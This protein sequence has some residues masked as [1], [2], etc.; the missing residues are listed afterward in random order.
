MNSQ[1]NKEGDLLKYINYSLGEILDKKNKGIN[2]PEMI[3]LYEEVEKYKN[4]I[5][6]RVN[7][8][9]RTIELIKPDNVMS[10][11]QQNAPLDIK[12]Y[13]CCAMLGKEYDVLMRSEKKW[14][15]VADLGL[16]IE[17]QGSRKTA[18]TD[19]ILQWKKQSE[20][21][22]MLKTKV[23]E[24]HAHYN[25]QS[26]NGVRERL[27]QVMHD[28]GIEQIVVPAIEYETNRQVCEMF[29]RAE[30]NYIKYAF[31]SH[32]K[33]LWKEAWSD[34]KWIEYREFLEHPKCVAVGET[35]LDYSYTEFCD[36]HRDKQIDM[37]AKFISEANQH[38]LPVI[39]HIRQADEGVVCK[40]NADE[41]VL[42][43][44]EKNRIQS[45]AILHCFGGTIEDVQKY[46]AAGVTAFGI[47]G[48][49]TYGNKELEDAVAMMPEST[50]V[51]ETDAPYIRVDGLHIP[52]TSLSLASI[53]KKIAELRHTTAE[54]ILR[55]SY[56][57]AERIYAR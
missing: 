1:L 48:R 12:Q 39:L 27:L 5:E 26:F 21:L 17:E 25:L 53:A 23:Y 13:V 8:C 55:I 49:I 45:G 47:G 51:L 41:D 56:E 22:I 9:V 24:T 10:W 36:E 14:K 7:A 54:H 30:Y 19:G 34:D 3:L 4:S 31:G 52:N 50:I 20:E 6:R 35:G 29:D 38:N 11:I 46:M 57:N 18:A 16:E 40:Y 43:I 32:P 42:M 28:S 44:L 37:F 2:T 15:T 33:Y